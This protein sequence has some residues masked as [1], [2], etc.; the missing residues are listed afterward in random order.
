MLKFGVIGL[1]SIAQKAYLP[2]MRGL[3]GVKWYLC[4]RN[5]EVL[6]REAAL[7]GRCVP[8]E[9]IE[10]LLAFELDGVFIHVAT[11]AHEA[12]ARA[13]LERGI[14]VYMDKPIADSYATTKELYQL[15][16]D[17]Q[18][19]LMA[20]FNRRFAPKVQA[21]KQVVDKTRILTEKNVPLQGTSMRYRLFDVFI[22][23]LDS[24]LYLMD[25][26]PTSGSFYYQKHQ[27]IL[28]QC[29]V[30][31]ASPTQTAIVL[32]N[33]AAGTNKE[34]IEVQSKN[35]TYTAENLTDL[36]VYQGGEQLADRFGSWETT[37]YKRGFESIISAFLQAVEQQ[38]ASPVSPQ[39]SLLSHDICERI[40]TSKAR[41]GF[42]T[43]DVLGFE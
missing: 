32:F 33:A 5:R 17:H 13:C 21:L 18:T 20:G 16:A 34:R 15:A 2:V 27:G 40:V 9:T 36:T 26:P 25:Q 41:E 7:F 1:G 4:T 38:S 3:S 35:G 43:F 10:D 29:T 30:Y 22:H 37:L 8:C 39:S 12:I 31:L 14:P 6:Q 19:F 28:E 42:L 11:H 24:A 23:P